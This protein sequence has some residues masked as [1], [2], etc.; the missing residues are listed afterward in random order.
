MGDPSSIVQWIT[1]MQHVQVQ[2]ATG[3]N[4]KFSYCVY[5]LRDS[6]SQATRPQNLSNSLR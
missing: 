4:R 5:V 6:R 3:M 2:S 1:A